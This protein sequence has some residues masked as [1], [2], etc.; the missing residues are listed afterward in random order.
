MA[1][2]NRD[3]DD[4]E[5]EAR[6]HL[7]RKDVRDA[8]RLF[9]LIASAFEKPASAK[10]ARSAAL[11]RHQLVQRAR[12]ILASRQLRLTHF[13]PAMF[14]EPAWEILLILYVAESEGERQT[15]SKLA[16]ATGTPLSTTI[17]WIDYLEKKELVAR[18]NHPTDKRVVFI[19]LRERAQ[20]AM[21]SY[22]GSI[23]EVRAP[24]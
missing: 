1:S 5:L 13:N 19:S 7:S 8:A 24:T 22:L 9:E 20:S 18:Q 21:D 2:G 16:A 10:L 17:R 12:A 3:Q 23:E 15:P 6:L 11:H 4:G 14:G